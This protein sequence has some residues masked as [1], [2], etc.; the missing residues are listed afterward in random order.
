MEYT[1]IT[2]HEQRDYKIRLPR[3]NNGQIHRAHHLKKQAVL[4]LY[5]ETT[6]YSQFDGTDFDRIII[7]TTDMRTMQDYEWIQY[8]DT[9]GFT[10]TCPGHRY[11][12]AIARDH[13]ELRDAVQ[14]LDET[15]CALPSPLSMRNLGHSAGASSS[16]KRQ[17]RQEP[18]RPCHGD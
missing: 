3:W 5:P 12:L 14:Y 4:V 17:R 7:L 1:I 6:I 16:A 10:R 18:D 13:G 8:H 2:L 11:L 9:D 15:E